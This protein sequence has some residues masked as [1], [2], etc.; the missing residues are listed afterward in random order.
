MLWES[1]RRYI[2]ISPF[3]WGDGIICERCHY[4]QRDVFGG[5]NIALLAVY[6]HITHRRE[7]S[8]IIAVLLFLLFKF[9]W[10]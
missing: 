8:L 1:R 2:R 7:L 6:I 5:L 9:T 10:K 3:T 4:L